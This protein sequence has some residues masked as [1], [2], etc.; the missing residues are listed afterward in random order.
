MPL[1]TY[2]NKIDKELHAIMCGMKQI[3]HNK[4]KRA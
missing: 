4:K 2:S 3:I 1:Q